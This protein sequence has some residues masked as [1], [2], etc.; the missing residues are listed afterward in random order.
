MS[1]SQ[2]ICQ[3]LRHYAFALPVVVSLLCALKATAQDDPPVGNE[4]FTVVEQPPS[5]QGGFAGLSDYLSKN[6]RYPAEAQKN[7][8][9]GKV[10]VT[11]IVTADGRIARVNVLKGIGNGCDEEAIRVIKQMPAWTPGRQA[12]KPVDVVF[13]LPINFSLK[14]GKF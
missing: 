10:F 1:Y 4:V 6:L 7:R 3:T 8:T 9:E 12:G 2:T 14:N 13:N 11:F 5:P